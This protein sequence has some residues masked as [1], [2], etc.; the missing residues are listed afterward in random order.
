MINLLWIIFFKNSSFDRNHHASC[1]HN[2]TILCFRMKMCTLSKI[3]ASQTIIIIRI[4][5]HDLSKNLRSTSFSL[6]F[7]KGWSRLFKNSFD[8]YFVRRKGTW[9]NNFVI[10]AYSCMHNEILP[11]FNCFSVGSAQEKK[12]ARLR[13]KNDVRWFTQLV[14]SAC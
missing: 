1:I 13:K 7:L 11:F 10:F 14:T 6:I 12:I 9:C 5:V 8:K 4:N 3:F 2:N